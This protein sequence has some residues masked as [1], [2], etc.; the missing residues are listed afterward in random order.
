MLEWA[1]SMTWKSIHPIVE[2]SRKVYQ[3]A[4]TLSKK[5][6]REV[7]A[8]LERHPELSKWDILI[9]PAST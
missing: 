3:K 4:V 7:E 1:K 6:M 8:R 5:A 9:R 2:F